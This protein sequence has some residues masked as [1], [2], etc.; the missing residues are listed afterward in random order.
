MEGWI[1]NELRS[2]CPP[3]SDAPNNCYDQYNDPCPFGFNPEGGCAEENEEIPINPP[4]YNLLLVLG[5]N[6]YLDT[7]LTIDQTAWIHASTENY[8]FALQ[9]LEML[10]NNIINGIQAQNWFFGNV[11]DF[12]IDLNI[13]PLLIS[14][15]SP[16][17]QQPLPTMQ[18]FLNNF[19]KLGTSGNYSQMPSTDV[20]YLV[21]GSLWN[22][23]QN[24]PQAYNNACAIRGSRGL[25]YSGI[26]IPVLN[27]S[28]QGQRTQK[29]GDQLNYILDA[30][31]FNKFMNNKFGAPTYNLEG[32][33]ANDAVQVSNLL[34]GKNGIY[35]II[36]NNYNQAGYSGHVDVIIDGICIGGALTTPNGGVKSISIWELN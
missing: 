1:L 5:L 9:I 17:S 10:Q 15:D 7:D 4:I 33:A 20:Y 36:N 26:H 18:D 11:P 14:Y 3:M 25:L 27:Y 22:S 32:T 34:N 21:G 8:E 2:P 13:N 24:N 6:S 28:N 35:V 12:E 30:V 23:H 31:S 29:G 19:P 16:L